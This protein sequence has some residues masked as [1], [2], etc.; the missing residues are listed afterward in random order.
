M[1]CYFL[2]FVYT[3]TICQNSKGINFIRCSLCFFFSCVLLIGSG[4][5]RQG[6]PAMNC[7]GSWTVCLCNAKYHLFKESI[8]PAL[9]LTWPG[10][11]VSSSKNQ[12]LVY[13]FFHVNN[14]MKIPESG[15]RTFLFSFSS[16]PAHTQAYT[17]PLLRLYFGQVTAAFHWKQ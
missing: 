6:S 5:W 16:L 11:E 8:K 12:I 10:F 14:L 17:P 9:A 3:S 4:S 13:K 15:T 1:G 2:L 7:Q